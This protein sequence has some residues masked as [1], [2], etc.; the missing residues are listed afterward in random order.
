M[1]SQGRRPRDIAPL[2]NPMS[3]SPKETGKEKRVSARWPTRRHEKPTIERWR[4]HRI[5]VEPLCGPKASL[6]DCADLEEA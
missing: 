4:I 1:Q 2:G 5:Q 3:S 6:P